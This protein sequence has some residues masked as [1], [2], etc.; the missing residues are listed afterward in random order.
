V[1]VD[2]Q[3]E[4][5]LVGVAR[6][7]WRRVSVVSESADKQRRDDIPVWCAGWRRSYDRGEV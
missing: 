3:C 7:Y 2:A 5:I 4:Q 6:V 1:R